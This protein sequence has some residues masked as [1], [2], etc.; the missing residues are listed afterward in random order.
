MSIEYFL[1]WESFRMDAY[2]Q[3]SEC[4]SLPDKEIG[5]KVK[6]IDR[7]FQTL[8]SDMLYQI[9]LLRKEDVEQ[10]DIA[11]LKIDYSR[12]FIGPSPP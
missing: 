3:L 2:I 11:A 7:D 10:N 12:L 6:K 1:N 9:N 4:Y 8:N 5:L